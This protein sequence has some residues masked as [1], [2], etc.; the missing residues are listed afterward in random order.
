MRQLTKLAAP[1]VV[2]ILGT[3]GFVVPV[4]SGISSCEQPINNYEVCYLVTQ[5]VERG[6]CNWKENLKW[7]RLYPCEADK[8]SKGG[9]TVYWTDGDCAEA[10]VYE[11]CARV[12]EACPC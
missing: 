7:W 9:T 12:N 6:C 10:G 3:L 4:A 2:A 1:L 11:Q 8:Y 5:D